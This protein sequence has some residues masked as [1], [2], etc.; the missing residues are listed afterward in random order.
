MQLAM[1]QKQ[2]EIQERQTAVAEIKAQFNQEIA[3][4]RLELDALKASQDFALRSDKMDLQE[5]QQQ[6]K[7]MVN[8]EELAIAKRAD[9][10]R[11][12]AS[13]NG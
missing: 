2:L 12:I 8:L 3:R 5:S 7:E 1:A 11:A 10:V 4:M 9:D 13:P 6:H